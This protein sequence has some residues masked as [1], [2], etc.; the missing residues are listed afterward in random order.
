MSYDYVMKTDDDV[1]LHLPNLLNRAMTLSRN[2]VY[3]G[4]E[5]TGKNFMAGAGY[6]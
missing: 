6:M 1:F 2:G 3:F 4:R 5:V